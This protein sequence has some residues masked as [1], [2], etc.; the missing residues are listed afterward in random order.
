M[1]A[2]SFL[3]FGA[4]AQAPRPL[5]A[6]DAATLVWDTGTDRQLGWNELLDRLAGLDAVFLGETHVDDT[7]HR[8][9]LHVLE[10][11]LTRKHGE[12]VL[13]MEMFEHDV[14]AVLDDYLQGRI[15]EPAFLAKARPWP[16]YRTAYRSL[17]EAAKLAGIPVVA[18]NFPGSLRRALA[19]GGKRAVDAL[20]PAERALMPDEIFP[21]SDAYWQRVERAVRGHMGGGGGGTPEERL[22]DTQNLWDNAMGDN[23]AK[24]RA[25]HPAST[26]LHV[27]GGFH[28]AYHDGTVAQF[29][30]RS[31][32]SRFAVVSIAPAAALFA[33]RPQRDAQQADY[34]VYAQ[35]LARDLDE[36][37]YAVEVPAELRYR[38]EVPEHGDALPLFVWLPDR[39]TRPEDAFTFWRR[40][41]GDRA[42]V[43]VLEQPFPEAQ[44]DLAVGGRYVSGDGFR[45]DYERMQLALARIVEYVTRRFPIDAH[46]VVVAGAGDGGAAVLWTALYGNWL[47][48]DLIAVDPGDLTR[49]SM[50]SLPDQQPVVR[51]LQ[52]FAC[53]TEQARLD[54]VAADCAKVGAAASVAT[55][56]NEP[57]ALV[58]RVRN[59]L[60]LPAGAAPAG[61]ATL[62]VLQN[63]SPRAREWAESYAMALRAQDHAARVVAASEVEAGTAKSRVRRLAVGGDGYWPVAAFADGA[64][65]PLAGGPFGGTTVVVLPKGVAAADRAAWLAHEQKKV[66]KRRSMFAN[67]AVASSDGEP[68]LPQVMAELRQRGRSRVLIV[69]A[70]FCADAATMR[71]LEQQL[72]QAGAGMDVSWLP[73]LGAALADAGR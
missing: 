46:R 59:Q 69:P 71:E 27:A 50:E 32:D 6:L 44:P 34:L 53:R 9:E 54:T 61:E 73:G 8:V 2:S 31:P 70:V 63:D 51:S 29:R 42:A 65:L 19:M 16:N 30:R 35:T 60:S 24:A 21:A 67:I 38:L 22:Y 23:V 7:T 58:D 64:G 66:I 28:V 4:V 57:L 45:A 39:T 52:L 10:G 40:A 18:A 55:L 11:L 13:S 5:P 25:A 41:L 72:G 47:D 15:D 33:A 3:L 49:L 37:T 56:A 20:S 68:T 14:Q 1:L 62:L 12:V 48:V 17:V 26:V 43:A 36:G